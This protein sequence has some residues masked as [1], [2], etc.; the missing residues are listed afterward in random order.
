MTAPTSLL[1][2]IALPVRNMADMLAFYE[3]YTTMKLIHER[4]DDETGL[5][6]IWL[7]H[8]YVRRMLRARKHAAHA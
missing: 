1:T 8:I 3:R 4:T 5:R 6:S 2:H 7:P